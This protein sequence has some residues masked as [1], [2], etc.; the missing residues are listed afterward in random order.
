MVAGVGAGTLFSVGFGISAWLAHRSRSPRTDFKR[1][2]RFARE[3]DLGLPE[4]LVSQVAAR[5]RRRIVLGLALSALLA[6]PLLGYL[7]GAF[8]ATLDAPALGGGEIQTV[9]FPGPA[10]FA[11]YVVPGILITALESVWDAARARRRAAT[12]AELQRQP[13]GAVQLRHAM[14]IQALWAARMLSVLPALVAA[15]A[16]AVQGRT[17]LAL[18]FVAL[19][20][21]CSLVTWS[22]ERLQLWILNTERPA[23]EDCL[24]PQQAAFD[25]AFRV[26]AALSLLPLGPCVCLLVGAFYIQL[27]GQ[28]FWYV[29]LLFAWSLTLFPIMG[30][31]GLLSTAWA[32][33]YH[34]K[35]V[36]KAPA[37]APASS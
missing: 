27:V 7:V 13:A 4:E 24:L 14:P 1:A 15:V 6:G 23:A 8:V 26:T 18:G 28:G 3:V 33:R 21:L 35:R 10:G 32:K 19:A 34:R 22:V 29:N 25:D 9:P 37:V 36:G 17:G 11:L 16:V 31:N 12:T 2:D 5:L 20:P 30:L